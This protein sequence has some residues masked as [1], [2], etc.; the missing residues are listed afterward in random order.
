MS[1]LSN[2]S[3]GAQQFFVSLLRLPSRGTSAVGTS[4]PYPATK[5]AEQVERAD[6]TCDED[7]HSVLSLVFEHHPARILGRLP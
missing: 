2:I 4:V 5:V 3:L 1:D 7:R 6:S